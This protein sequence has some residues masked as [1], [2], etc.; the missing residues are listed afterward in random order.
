MLK[1]MSGANASKLDLD[2]SVD[3]TKVKFY[4]MEDDDNPFHTPVQ[5][6]ITEAIHKVIGYFNRKGAVSKKVYFKQFKYGFE[7]WLTAM[8]D[9]SSPNTAQQLTNLKS[10]ISPLKEFFKSLLGLSNYT[11][12]GIALCLS[13]NI[14]N[15]I[16]RKMFTQMRETL[17]EELHKLL[18]NSSPLKTNV[19][20][21]FWFIFR[22]GWNS[23]ISRSS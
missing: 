7:L 6:D 13:E 1:V 17:T 10:E 12:C 11:T 9:K 22:K 4:Y 3:L 18:G 19:L 14:A 20:F 21:K 16:D 23:H 2:K 5:P 15:N 8:E